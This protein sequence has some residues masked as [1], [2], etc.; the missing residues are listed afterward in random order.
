MS[1]GGRRSCR[2]SR[3]CRLIMRTKQGPLGLDIFYL[4]VIPVSNYNSNYMMNHFEN[5]FN[6]DSQEKNHHSLEFMSLVL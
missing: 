5:I 4:Q 2:G 3:R 6:F 1:A